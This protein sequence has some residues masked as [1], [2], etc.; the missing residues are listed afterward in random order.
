MKKLVYCFAAVALG[1]TVSCSSSGYKISGTSQEM[2]HQG[3]TLYL[4]DYD[5]DEALDSVVISDS[6]FVFEGKS[7]QNRIAAVKKN[8]KRLAV[9]LLEPGEINV[10]FEMRVAKGTPL[11]DLN[12]SLNE[13]ANKLIDDYNSKSE[14]LK[15]SGDKEKLQM[16][17]ASLDSTLTA[18]NKTAFEENK[19]NVLGLMYFLDYAYYLDKKQLDAELASLPEFYRN[20]VRVGRYL[21]A[22]ENSEKTAVGQMFTDFTV[23]QSDGTVFKLSDVVGKGNFVLV[24][25]WASWC[26]PCRREM[27]GLKEINDKYAAKGL[28]IVGVA[29]WDEPKDTQRA[30]AELQL[31]WQIVDNAQR[32]PTDIYGIMGIPHI[33][34]F[35]PDGK[36]QFRG[37]TGEELKKAVDEVMAESK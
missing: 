14:E 20:S 28:K 33:I 19:D 25:F 13:K 1:M 7:S 24:D 3:D 10:D 27:P 32:V 29:V 6:T 16:M 9:F 2:I 30:V 26:G 5:T 8:G 34:M 15:K 17:E 35:A 31:P 22:A 37:L 23:K 18:L 36:I 4:V 21:K 12:Y 11:N